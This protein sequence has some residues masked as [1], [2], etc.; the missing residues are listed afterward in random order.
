[1][2]VKSALNITSVLGLKIKSLCGLNI[3]CPH[4]KLYENNHRIILYKVPVCVLIPYPCMQ[5]TIQN[6]SHL[7]L[8][9]HFKVYSVY[10]LSQFWD[11][12]FCADKNNIKNLKGL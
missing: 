7:R 6:K 8:S 12:W 11:L 1:M 3:K 10:N 4:L 9:L 5:R 2:I